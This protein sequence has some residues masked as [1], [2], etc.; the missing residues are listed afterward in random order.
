MTNL[1]NILNA[2]VEFL[3]SY[4]TLTLKILSAFKTIVFTL[5]ICLWLPIWI[6]RPQPQLTIVLTPSKKKMFGVS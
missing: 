2:V 3:G 6:L 5:A 4:A 1:T